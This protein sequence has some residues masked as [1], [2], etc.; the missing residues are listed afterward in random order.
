MTDAEK[1]Q[2][3]FFNPADH[4]DLDASLFLDQIDEIASVLHLT[5]GA[6]RDC[7]NPLKPLIPRQ[8]DQRL[9]H[10]DPAADGFVGQLPGGKRPIPQP[11]HV[12]ES[13]QN[14]VTGVGQYFSQ[15][16][17]NRVGSDIDDGEFGHGRAP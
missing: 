3:G 1:N 14:L 2:P 16:H 5:H 12:F 7:G 10:T 4:A 11:G 13:I 9:Q 15:H 6:G 8:G 17:M